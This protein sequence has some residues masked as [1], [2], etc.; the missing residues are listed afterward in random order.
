MATLLETRSE[1]SETVETPES[2]GLIGAGLP[3]HTEGEKA[4]P[5]LA[6]TLLVPLAPADQTPHSHDI[7]GACPAPAPKPPHT[8][9]VGVLRSATT[10]ARRATRRVAQRVVARQPL[11]RNSTYL[12]LWGAKTVSDTGSQ[13]SQLAFPLLVLLITHSAAIA[14]LAGALR[15]LPYLVLTLPAGALVDR[16]DRRKVML[17]CDTGRLITLASIPLALALGHLGVLQIFA[18]SLIEGIFYV[19]FDLAELA[20]LPVVVPQEQMTAAAAQYQGLTYSTSALLGPALGGALFAAGRM[21][22]FVTDAISYG[23]SV[24]ALW[25]VKLPRQQ[26]GSPRASAQSWH[27]LRHDI[28]G[29]IVWLWRQPTLRAMTL[30]LGLSNVLN[31]G[32]ALLVIVLAE[33]LH[34]SMAEI[35]LVLTL[36]GLGAVVGSLVAGRVVA[37]LSFSRAFIGG[38]WAIAL[39]WLLYA[40]APTP[41]ALG[42]V[43]AGV[44]LLWSLL[45]V[46]QFSY[47]MSLIPGDLQ[48]R[49]S[50]IIRLSLYGSVPVSLALTGALIERSGPTATALI[51]GLGLL[52]SAGASTL[53]PHIRRAQPAAAAQVH[54]ST[55]HD[56]DAQGLAAA[57]SSAS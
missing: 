24:A 25:H 46:A 50:S 5:E 55:T 27:T 20:L 51:L 52:A 29:G 1:T 17:I 8:R 6:Q 43:M 22:P 12:T 2:A 45:N 26:A 3:T 9:A 34:A 33:H 16:W 19:F 36:G 35:G 56:S 30:L 23:V 54:S 42:F 21:L 11:W 44:A 15:M 37:R 39:L 18:V 7:A 40:V 13:I 14:G 38:N 53:N 32:E 4:A 48:G 47:R 28:A 31:A 41:L 10:R 57:T 49:I